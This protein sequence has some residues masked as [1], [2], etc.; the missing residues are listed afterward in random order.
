MAA[1]QRSTPRRKDRSSN[2]STEAAI[3]IFHAVYVH[4][5]FRLRPGGKDEY[6][7]WLPI[8]AAARLSEKIPELQPWLIARAEKLLQVVVHTER[9]QRIRIVSA[10][11]ATKNEKPRISNKSQTNWARLD[12]LREKHI[13]PSDTPEIPPEMFAKAVL[14]HG[15]E[16]VA[17]KAQITLRVDRDVLEWF[18]QQGQGYQTR[19]NALLRA[20]MEAHKART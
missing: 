10:R 15:L 20:Y 7:R 19:I 6:R 14:R 18:K 11:K 5:Y 13:D 8:V 3:R 4:R 2:S 12:A 1:P 9:G 16:P 17:P